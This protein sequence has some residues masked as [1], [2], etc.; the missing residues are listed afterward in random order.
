MVSKYN[1]ANPFVNGPEYNHAHPSR[2]E[3][4]EII[5]DLYNG[6]NET[7]AIERIQ[8]IIP[9]LVGDITFF[10]LRVNKL[11]AALAPDGNQNVSTI[12]GANNSSGSETKI[13]EYLKALHEDLIT[14]SIIAKSLP[15]DEKHIIQPALNA[16]KEMGLS[17]TNEQN[18]Q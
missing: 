15:N 3:I 11:K 5:S 2:S 7:K 6:E 17:I 14:I 12:G 16:L 13:F 9:C 4:R 10:S 8:E 1:A 18:Q